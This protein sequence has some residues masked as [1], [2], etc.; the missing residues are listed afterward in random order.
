[1]IADRTGQRFGMLVIK[2]MSPK[3]NCVCL[4]D[5]GKTHVAIVSNIVRGDTRS[6][7]CRH[8][9]MLKGGIR[10]THGHAV[11]R[12]TTREF[13]SWLAM[14]QRCNDP[15]SGKYPRYGGRGIVVCGQWQNSFEN[16]LDDMGP[17]PKGYTLGRQDN[18]GPYCPGNCKWETTEEQ[19]NNRSNNRVIEFAGQQLTL[20]RWAL[21][22]GMTYAA[23]QSRLDRG[24]PLE[25]ALDPRVKSRP[26]P[27][28]KV[29]QIPAWKTEVRT[30]ADCGVDFNPVGS[31]SKCCSQSCRKRWTKRYLYQRNADAIKERR[32]AAKKDGAPRH[33]LMLAYSTEREAF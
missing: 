14:R 30:C 28:R 17:C 27:P 13:N 32:R 9:A 19:A 15:K 29:K 24:W 26:K 18:D 21:R 23:L 8:L 6:C 25:L 20:A 16:F 2:K 3:G 7:G 11:N 10:L 31:R 12:T 1:M 22:V 33:P 5:C 4:C